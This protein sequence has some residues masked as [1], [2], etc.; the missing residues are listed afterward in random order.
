M[1]HDQISLVCKL[2]WYYS[3]EIEM[4]N[5]YPVTVFFVDKCGNSLRHN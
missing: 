1:Y 3:N 5:I 4:R 2:I